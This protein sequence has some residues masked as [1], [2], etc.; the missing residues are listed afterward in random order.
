[1]S[2]RESHIPHYDGRLRFLLA[3][4]G[5][6]TVVLMWRVV[7]LH[8]FNR[9]F[10][11]HQ[12][13]AR[14]LRVVEVAAHRGMI[15]DRH[16]E[17]LAISTPVESVWANPKELAAARDQ[18][19]VLARVLEL[20]PRAL[21]Q[22]L[23]KRQER[24]FVYLRRHI[25]PE[26]AQQ[27]MAL[28]I[29][30]VALQR[31][32]RRYYP[33]GEVFAHVVGFT[34]IDDVGQ[35]GMEL[36]YNDWL[37]GTPGSKRVIKDRL[38]RIVEN[39]E[40]IS[41]PRPGQDLRLA[42]DRRIQYLAY[43]ELKAVVQRSQ[44]RAGSAVVL[45]VTSGEVL[46]MVNQPAYNPNNRSGLSSERLRNRTATDVFEPGSTIKP[47]TVAAALESGKFR[48][49]TVIDTGS[50]FLRVSSR[51]TVR[52]V[53]NYGRID[54]SRVIQKS[55]NVGAA[56]MALAIKPQQLWNMFSRL[57]FGTITASAFPGEATGLLTDYTRWRETERATLSYGY[58]LSV[59]ALQLAQAYAALAADGRMHSVTLLPVAGEVPESQRVMRPQIAQQVR[60]MLE[61]A[62]EKD[63]TGSRAAVPGYR[64]GGKTGTVHK[65]TTGGYSE[66]RYLALFA[67][68]A[69]ASAPRLAMVVVIDEPQGEEYYGGQVAAPVFSRV[70]GGALRLLDIAPDDLESLGVKLA[71]A[72]AP[73]PVRNTTRGVL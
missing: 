28:E 18:W 23:A 65:V 38:G 9:E 13:D 54:V 49:D 59:T 50:G 35:E 66:D 51:L 43:R 33:A 26:L 45:D 40:S 21:E 10:L 34:N 5:L 57:G 15:T 37:K 30:G 55:S 68:F 17:P 69:P 63:G 60:A 42:L 20:P 8:V 64:V 62:V 22:L 29:P 27:V 2:E 61:L 3:L 53:H 41:E 70:M 44:A 56:T 46:A 4:L 32:Y 48:P 52:D 58:G 67:G 31:E 7:D 11:Q 24:E 71:D 39:V 25:T 6:A 47:F 36:L 1:M 73:A 19:K 72:P 12:G 14:A 16:G